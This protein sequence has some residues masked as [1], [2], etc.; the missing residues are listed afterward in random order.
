MNEL[1]ELDVKVK[2][3]MELFRMNPETIEGMPAPTLIDP[4]PV[5]DDTDYRV[6]RSG[7]IN[8]MREFIY[9]KSEM[10]KVEKESSSKDHKKGD[11]VSA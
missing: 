9:E 4:Y 6:A 3:D 11:T 10:S 1:M 5:I 7:M 2:Q 8:S